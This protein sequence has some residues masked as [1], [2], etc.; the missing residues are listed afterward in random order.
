MGKIKDAGVKTI[1]DKDNYF[2]WKVKMYLHLLSI[3]ER[4]ANCI[5][6]GPH[7]SM[8]VYTGTRADGEDIVGKMIPKPIHKY[9]PEDT[10]E[11]HKDKKTINI[12]FNGLD[13]DMFDSVISCSTFK[14]VWDTIRTICE[15][16][17]QVRGN[18]IQLLIQQYESFH[19]K[20][21]ESLSDTFNRF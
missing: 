13:Q 17:E 7:A 20:A 19:F 14:E 4:Y 21:G 10:E 12:L 18:N 1:L 9:S 2:H 11:V 5:E 15:G 6:K 3:D 16:N 8:K